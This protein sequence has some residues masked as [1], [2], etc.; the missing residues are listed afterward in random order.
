MNKYPLAM[1]NFCW[2]NE[3]L[4]NVLLSYLVL[5]LWITC[6]AAIVPSCRLLRRDPLWALGDVSS[7]PSLIKMAESADPS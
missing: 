6:L 5:L 2:I 1:L 7:K 3:K 4:D